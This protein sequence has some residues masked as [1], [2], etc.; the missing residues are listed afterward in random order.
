[1]INRN[2]ELKVD[3]ISRV[4]SQHITSNSANKDPQFTYTVNN[5]SYIT[6]D[7]W[8]ILILLNSIAVGFIVFAYSCSSY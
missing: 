2:F 4:N 7:R 3:P 1:M 6:L 5:L 8:I